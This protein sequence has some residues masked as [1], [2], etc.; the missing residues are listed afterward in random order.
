MILVGHG[1]REKG[2]SSAM[3][4]V[5]S[6]IRRGGRYSDV[7][8]AY[9]EIASPSIDDAIGRAAAKRPSE[10]R[11]LPYFVL[12]GRHVNFHIPALVRSA[13]RKYGRLS[14]IVLCPYLGYDHRLVELAGKRIAEGK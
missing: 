2:F 6:A 13:K 9:L 8:C 4:K 10:I 1:S 7:S 14:R 5:A 11:V 3:R 12:S